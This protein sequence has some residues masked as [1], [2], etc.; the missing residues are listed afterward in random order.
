M[1]AHFAFLAELIFAG[2]TKLSVEGVSV[3]RT[4]CCLFQHTEPDQQWITS[5]CVDPPL[6]SW[7]RH[8]K[9][10]IFP[11][12][13]PVLY[14]PKSNR[15]HSRGCLLIAPTL[16]VPKRIKEVSEPPKTGNPR[17]E[18]ELGPSSSM[19]REAPLPSATVTLTLCSL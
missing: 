19:G 17:D 8:G 10:L 5:L 14:L 9:A 4:A 2:G 6:L 12:D 11:T 15:L 16:K 7:L 3:C 13:C 1:L 18:E